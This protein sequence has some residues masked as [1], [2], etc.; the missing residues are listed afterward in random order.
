MIF[1]KSLFLLLSFQP[2]SL[3]GKF[4]MILMI[5]N[6]LFARTV[7]FF[8]ALGLPSSAQEKLNELAMPLPWKDGEVRKQGQLLYRN[9]CAACHGQHLEGENKDWHIP[10]EEGL[11]PAPPHNDFGH[12][13]HHSE[14]LLFR[15]TK[16]GTSIAMERPETPSNMPSFKDQLSDPE[17]IAI[18]SFIKSSWSIEN[19][20]FNDR[21]SGL[22]TK[23]LL[24][25]PKSPIVIN[26]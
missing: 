18:L 10:D 20:Q 1:T 4:G 7:L 12:T 9:H 8:L 3:L 2:L 21:A 17:I 13:W 19:R 5:K 25:V 11:Y 23:P 16:Y 24:S 22:G 14:E 15:M 26:K 6:G